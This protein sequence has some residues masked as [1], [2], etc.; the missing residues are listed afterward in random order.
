M[1][2]QICNLARII[3]EFGYKYQISSIE[4]IEGNQLMNVMDIESF[5]LKTLIS[6]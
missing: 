1:S 3:S 5:K 2:F 6:L 4:Q